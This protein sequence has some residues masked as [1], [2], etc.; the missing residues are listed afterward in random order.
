LEYFTA[1]GYILWKFGIVCGHLVIFS[2]FGL[3]GRRKIWQPWL[4]RLAVTACGRLG[5]YFFRFR[6]CPRKSRKG[7]LFSWTDFFSCGREQDP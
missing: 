2:V 1:I 4:A 6:I 3:F 7:K 5:G